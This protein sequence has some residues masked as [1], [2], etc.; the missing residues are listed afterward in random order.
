MLNLKS[1]VPA[2]AACEAR[3]LHLNVCTRWDVWHR[4]L[5]AQLE[6]RGRSAETLLVV[7]GCQ[8]AEQVW[9]RLQGESRGCLM[10]ATGT[11]VPAVPRLQPCCLMTQPAARRQD[12]MAAE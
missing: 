12:C 5:L 6:S 11:G 9:Q 2:E 4:L 7:C 3:R 1:R 8:A 10:Q